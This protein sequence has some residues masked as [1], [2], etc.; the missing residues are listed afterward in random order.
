MAIGYF[1]VVI[2]YSAIVLTSNW[3]HYA[4]LALERAEMK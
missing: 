4:E 2:L 1:F 3:Q